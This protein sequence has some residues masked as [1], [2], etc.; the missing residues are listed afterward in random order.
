MIMEGPMRVEIKACRQRRH[1][2]QEIWSKGSGAINK[3]ILENLIVYQFHV[4]SQPH[5]AQRAYGMWGLMM[6]RE[7][8]SLRCRCRW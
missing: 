1:V 6:A 5:S 2:A 8:D 3:D 4:V 7:V